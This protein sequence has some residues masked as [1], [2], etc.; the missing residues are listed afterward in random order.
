MSSSAKACCRERPQC[1]DKK[2]RDPRSG[3]GKAQQTGTPGGGPG[4]AGEDQNRG[5]N[6]LR[7]SQSLSGGTPVRIPDIF[8][9]PEAPEDSE[10]SRKRKQGGINSDDNKRRNTST[11]L[12]AGEERGKMNLSEAS[13]TTQ[14]RRTSV[15]PIFRAKSKAGEA[16]PQEVVLGPNP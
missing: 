9:A 7:R 1:P 8:R 11:D 6:M 16:A 2:P 3:K 5:R 10:G 12:E 13:H 4:D 15:L 14:T